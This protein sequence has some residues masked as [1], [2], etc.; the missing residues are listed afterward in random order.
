MFA[1]MTT[2]QGSPTNVADGIKAVNEQVIP[3]AQKMRGFKAV[4]QEGASYVV[5]PC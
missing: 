1:R 2:L 5:L 4:I 3:A